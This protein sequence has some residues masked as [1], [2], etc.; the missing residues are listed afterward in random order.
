MRYLIFS[1]WFIIM[2][3]VAYML[4][5]AVALKISKDIYE[6]DNRLMTYLKDMSVE[7]ERKYV[8]KW[9]FPAQLL[10]G[11]LMSLVLYPILL[12]LG[13]MDFGLRFI[14]LFAL[15]FI[16]T[17][18]VS[19]SPCPDNIEGFVYMKEKFFRK[20]SFLKF[21]FEM[22]SYSLVLAFFSSYFLF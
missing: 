1:V 3:T 14:F 4:A 17:H 19:V 12:P 10:R 5:G 11:F 22:I 16:Y 13:E 21:Q 20:S 9:V 15:L 6:G 2:H 8:E 18:L 7:D